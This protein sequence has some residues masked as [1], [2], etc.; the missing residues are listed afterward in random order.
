ML[1]VH[2]GRVKR[3]GVFEHAQNDI[4]R[5]SDLSHAYESRVGTFLISNFLLLTSNF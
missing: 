5:Y 3:K 1:L 2:I 4:F